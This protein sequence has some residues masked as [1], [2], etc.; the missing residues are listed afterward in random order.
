[1]CIILKALKYCLL[2]TTFI[3]AVAQQVDANNT[4]NQDLNTN[5]DLTKLCKEFFID[6]AQIEGLELA[7]FSIDTISHELGHAI[8]LKTLF[9]VHDPIQIHI[10]TRTPEE[11]PQI[12]SLGN[13][14]FY[15]TIPWKSGLT[16]SIAV[17]IK[18]S[19][20]AYENID[21]CIGTA[22]GG[23]SAAAF[24]VRPAGAPSIR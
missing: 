11:T 10:G 18:K 12:F 16:K 4:Q 21:S 9:N 3:S 15:K 7:I 19:R 23:L 8:A 17:S 14:H 2:L 1:M 13:M 6:A 24:M 5:H 22:A 20:T